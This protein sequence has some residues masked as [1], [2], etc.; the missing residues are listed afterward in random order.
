[1][2]RSPMNRRQPLL[3]IGLVGLLVTCGGCPRPV[4]EPQPQPQAPEAAVETVE[5][6]P[7][8][9]FTIWLIEVVY[10]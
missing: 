8:P 6:L 9:V 7:D 10:N 2:S 3:P 4:V 1:M 5:Q